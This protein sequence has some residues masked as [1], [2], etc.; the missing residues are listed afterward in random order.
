MTTKRSSAFSSCASAPWETSFT[1][2]PR[3]SS[4]RR[5]SP[6]DDRMAHRRALG[7]ALVRARNPRRGPRSAQRPLADRVHTVNLTAWRQSS[8]HDFNSAADRENLERR[9]RRALRRR[10]RSSGRDALRSAGTMVR[11]TRCVW[12]GR[13]PRDSCHPL[14]HAPRDRERN[15]RGRAESLVAAAVTGRKMGVPPIDSSS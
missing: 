11:C 12:R 15:A 1:P 5:V 7:R 10:R 2:C 6:C 8:V 14:V 4:T 3:R 13:A 9:A